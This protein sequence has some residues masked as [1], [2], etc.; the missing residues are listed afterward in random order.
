M[1]DRSLT[2]G[3]TNTPAMLHF[4]LMRHAPR[5]L[6]PAQGLAAPLPGEIQYF[7]IR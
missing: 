7:V 2:R 3:K 1:R 4:V 6:V 5:F